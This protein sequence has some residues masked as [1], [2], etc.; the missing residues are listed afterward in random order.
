MTA[1]ALVPSSIIHVRHGT[2]QHRL[3]RKGLSIWIDLDRLDDA[4]AQSSFFSVG[5]FNL[6]SFSPKDYGPN[7]KSNA[8]RQDLA[9]YARSLAGAIMPDQAIDQVMLLTFPRILG[10]SFN[11][12]SVYLCRHQGQ[13]IL[14]IYEVRNTF[15]DMHSYIG[16]MDGGKATV[17]EVKKNLHVSPFFSMDGDYRLKINASSDAMRLL[18]HYHQEGTP[19]LTATLR[20]EI[21]PM[22]GKAIVKEMFSAGQFPL[23][24]LISIH[25]EAVKLWLKRVTFFRRPTPSINPWTET[26]VTKETSR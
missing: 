22:S 9:A 26:K 8:P 5:S 13:D 19:L 24:P 11:P 6:L 2:P 1:C 20:G 4:A 15:G 14:A 23:R 3:E 7:F 10:V 18:I 25:M 21:I 17:H 12:I 16:R